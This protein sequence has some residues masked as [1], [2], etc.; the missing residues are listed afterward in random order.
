MGRVTWWGVVGLLVG[1]CLGGPPGPAVPH[2][3]TSKDDGYCLSCHQDGVNGAPKAPHPDRDNCTGCHEAKEVV[4]AGDAGTA[5]RIPPTVTATD[6]DSC[7][8]CHRDGAGGAP[9]T[10]HVD[11]TGCTSCHA[12]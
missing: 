3:V 11:R 2:A 9:R 8:G 1:G 10:A 6:D 5:P 12:R 4:S 7:L